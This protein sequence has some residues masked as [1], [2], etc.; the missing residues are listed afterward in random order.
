MFYSLIR[1]D[2]QY[3]TFTVFPSL[4]A[5]SPRPWAVPNC[6]G[7]G[8]HV[9][10]ISRVNAGGAVVP[11]WSAHGRHICLASTAAV[12]QSRVLA[13]IP[14]RDQLDSHQCLRELVVSVPFFGELL[15]LLFFQ[16]NRKN[17]LCLSLLLLSMSI[18]PCA[19]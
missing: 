16:N 17:W 1:N 4:P 19:K 12:L 14:S 8:R 3:L 5:K 15:F 11:G 7:P 9:A 13:T 18:L 6:R 2:S 10:S